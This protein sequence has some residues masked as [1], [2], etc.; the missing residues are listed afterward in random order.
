MGKSYKDYTVEEVYKGA[1]LWLSND[2]D[3]LKT[4]EYIYNRMM[5]FNVPTTEF[6]LLE[7]FGSGSGNE[8]MSSL[9][10][11]DDI[12]FNAEPTGFKHMSDDEVRRLS[13]AAFHASLDSVL[14]TFNEAKIAAESARAR[15]DNALEKVESERRSV[16]AVING[17]TNDELLRKVKKIEESSTFRIIGADSNSISFMQDTP[18]ILTHMDAEASINRRHDMGRYV[19][20]LGL[21]D[22]GRVTSISVEAGHNTAISD[23]YIHP[24][25]SSGSICFGTGSGDA[26]LAMTRKDYPKLLSV[27]DRLL[28]TMSTGTPYREFYHFCD[29]TER[30]CGLTDDEL[31]RVGLSRDGGASMPDTTSDKLYARGADGMIRKYSRLQEFPDIVK[32]STG[33]SLLSDLTVIDGD[34]VLPIGRLNAG[35]IFMHAGAEFICTSSMTGIQVGSLWRKTFGRDIL[36]E[37]CDSPSDLAKSISEAMIGS[38]S[39]RIQRDDDTI[40]LVRMG[41]TN[42]ILVP[43]QWREDRYCGYLYSDLRASTPYVGSICVSDDAVFLGVFNDVEEVGADGLVDGAI[44]KFVYRGVLHAGM[45]AGNRLKFHKCDYGALNVRPGNSNIESQ[46]TRLELAPNSEAVETNTIEEACDDC[47]E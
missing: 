15:Y 7:K 8:L 14:Q 39:T 21:G 33:C 40:R 5:A 44:Y 4:L 19:C 23:G 2:P 9:A 47:V 1:G 32:D 42:A 31:S 37:M 35:D 46:F 36:V 10:E 34:K 29:S 22:D 30:V 13:V 43:Q 26:S 17:S 3:A 28:R 12:I 38:V 16:S 41:D 45:F 11:I 18:T 6:K 25:V 27:T 20:R 24:N